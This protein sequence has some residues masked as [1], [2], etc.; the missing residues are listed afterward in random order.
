MI[1]ASD[2]TGLHGN[3]FSGEDNTLEAAV[4]KDIIE[5]AHLSSTPHNEKRLWGD[6][7]RRQFDKNLAE[8]MSKLSCKPM[9]IVPNIEL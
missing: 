8:I 5:F 1:L 6:E 9:Y 7:S 2:D 3:V 4:D